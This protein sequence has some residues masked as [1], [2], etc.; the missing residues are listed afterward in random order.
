MKIPIPETRENGPHP[1]I[2][3]TRVVE[4][5]LALEEYAKSLG[6]GVSVLS[7]GEKKQAWMNHVLEKYGS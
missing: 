5:Q 4:I 1:Y 3:D 2:I 6:K 7:E